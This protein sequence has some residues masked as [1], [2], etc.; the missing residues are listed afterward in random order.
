MKSRKIIIIALTLVTILGL[1]GCTKMTEYDT[2]EDGM[3]VQDV[4]EPETIVEED[5]ETKKEKNEFYQQYF[6]TS[7]LK[8]YGNR[9]CMLTLGEE[10]I[11]IFRGENVSY[12]RIK[13]INPSTPS[14]TNVEILKFKES[15][16]IIQQYIMFQS[17]ENNK[18]KEIWLEY[19]P[20][21]GNGLD[22]LEDSVGKLIDATNTFTR[23]N[24][25]VIEYLHTNDKGLDTVKISI[26][27]E[28]SF[29]LRLNP[30]TN[31]V[32]SIMLYS[33]SRKAIAFT[34]CDET[35][36]SRPQK[37]TK[38]KLDIIYYTLKYNNN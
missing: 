6:K 31:E 12:R 24:G 26:P 18:M 21:T 16:E 27:T 23:M 17:I 4:I 1:T 28:E 19:K 10:C 36:I 35:K 30:N 11:E 33:L 25:A 7:Q 14:R 20:G 32:H 13:Y 38:N 15:N 37:T 34:E 2:F 22:S 29:E 3:V 8:A 9:M 5:E